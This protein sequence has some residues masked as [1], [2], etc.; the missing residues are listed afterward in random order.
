LK[1]H[2]QERLPAEYLKCQKGINQGLKMAW[3]MIITDSV[4]QSNK[5]QA[6]SL[7]S[8]CYRYQMDLATN[9]IIITDSLKYV[10]GKMNNLNDQ[11]KKL[12]QNIK[13]SV[14]D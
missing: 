3:N 13:R 6:L 1:Y 10:Q 8:E 2:I 7:I 4:N 5:L 9:G 12:L 14:R 11:E